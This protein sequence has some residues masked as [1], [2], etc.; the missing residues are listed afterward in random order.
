LILL[1][2]K[3]FFLFFVFN[4]NIF[5]NE[6]LDNKAIEEIIHEK[7]E[8]RLKILIDPGHGGKDPGTI[9]RF[10]KLKEKDIV[11][12]IAKLLEKKLTE[13]FKIYLTR[14]TDKYLTLE[15]RTRIANKLKCD[16]FISLHLNYSSNYETTGLQTFY[17]N[18]TN[19][20]GVI[21]LAR[22]EN[23]LSNTLEFIKLDLAKTFET[24]LSVDFA[25]IMHKEIITT[26]SQH[27]N[28][29]QDQGVKSAIFYVLWGAK[30]PSILIE[31]G[32]LS[33][34]KEE[35]LFSN[36]IFLDRLT[37]GIFSGIKNYRKIF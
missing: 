17:L 33:N 1:I 21:K 27:Y 6:E 37:D 25:K 26:M 11:L 4:T 18:N 3:I 32:F 13:N 22:R 9:G 8:K 14:N 30:M 19:D 34:K 28:T 2:L 31:L 16:L 23:G 10:K 35:K 7:K 12:S 36:K 15:E 24:N 5:S 20:E 29:S